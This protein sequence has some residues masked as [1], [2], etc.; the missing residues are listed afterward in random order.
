ME[1]ADIVE[2][3]PALIS[4]VKKLR[5]WE[6]T[7]YSL[8]LCLESF[9]DEDREDNVFKTSFAKIAVYLFDYDRYLN[10]YNIYLYSD[11]TF[12]V[13]RP[14][15]HKGYL[16][17]TPINPGPSFETWAYVLDRWVSGFAVRKRQIGRALKLKQELFERRFSPEKIEME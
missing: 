11:G 12:V 8:T 13:D 2:E 14:L 4:A 3:L 5:S 9:T 1:T 6:N 10:E 7:E 16:V 17:P 15:Y